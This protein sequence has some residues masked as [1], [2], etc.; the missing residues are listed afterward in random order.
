MS[1]L[2]RQ[3]LR[4]QNGEDAEDPVTRADD[5]ENREPWTVAAAADYALERDIELARLEKENEE[6]KRL[7][8]L[9]PPQPRKESS[10][11]G[12]DFR[13]IFEAPNAVRLPSMQKVVPPV[14][15]PREKLNLLSVRF[16]S[17]YCALN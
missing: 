10:G 17:M 7:A 6:L 1:H 5:E 9:L 15:I 16:H 11:V 4:S 2:L 13:P 3:I 14:P 12:S 8:G